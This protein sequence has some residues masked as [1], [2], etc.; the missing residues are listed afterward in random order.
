MTKTFWKY[1]K[2]PVQ[3]VATELWLKF[4]QLRDVPIYLI[5]EELCK[6]TE[7]FY[8]TKV[9]SNA[10]IRLT[11]PLFFVCWLILLICLPINYLI[12]GEWGYSIQWFENWY[13]R[14]S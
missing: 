4:P 13:E 10:F 2:K 5:E 12:K 6:D 9:K 11:L 3:S 8:Q 7:F 1:T 14:L